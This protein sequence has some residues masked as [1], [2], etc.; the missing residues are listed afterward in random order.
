MP[1]FG[2]SVLGIAFSIWLLALLCRVQ[3]RSWVSPA[4]LFALIWAAYMPTLLFFVPNAELYVPGM[5]WILASVAATW[6]GSV[7]AGALMPSISARRVVP[8]PRAVEMLKQLVRW[9]I[10]M[11]LADALWLFAQRGFSFTNVFS[12]SALMLVSAANRGEQYAGESDTPVLER[13]AFVALYLGAF[14]GGLLFRLSDRRR[15]KVLGFSALLTIILINTLHGSRFGSIY[16]GAFWLSAYLAGHVALANPKEGVGSGFLVRFGTAAVVIVF[17]FSMV[18]MTI[19]YTVLSDTN[20]IPVAW[21]Y[22]LTDP[23]GFIAAFGVW[24]RESGMHADGPFWGVRVFRRIAMLF[25]REYPLYEVVDVGFNSAN[26]FTIFRELIEDFTLS[27]SLVVLAFYGFI[28]RVAF[29]MTMRDDSR[30][31]LPWLAIAYVFAFTSVASSAFAY[32][33]VL[34]GALLFVATFM[35]LPR[36]AIASGEE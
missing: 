8:N 22:M 29:S 23:F 20:D 21:S 11:G 13:F 31:A 12:F 5:L 32:T 28:A 10:L 30:L 27:G 36:V 26:V 7:V 17:V 2:F 19:R 24:F 9:P 14:Y 35:V 1:P 16:G 34:A 15:E 33:T 18:T 6:V 3:D 4:S 25:G